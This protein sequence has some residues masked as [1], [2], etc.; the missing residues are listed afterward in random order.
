MALASLAL[1]RG[2]TAPVTAEVRSIDG[3]D[4]DRQVV[5][6]EV[7]GE[8][9]SGFRGVPLSLDDV[10]RWSRPPPTPPASEGMPL[11][12]VMASTGADIVEGIAALDGWGRLA[13]ALVD[14]SGIVPTIVVVDGPAVSGP[15]LLLGVADLVVMTEASYAFV[16][17]PVMVEEFTGVAGHHRRARRRGRPG[18]PHRRAEPRR[19][20]PRG[21]ARAPSS[22]L[23]DYL[24]VER[25]R[26]AA[27]AGRPTTRSTGRAP[28][29]AS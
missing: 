10:G 29:P 5:W 18:P 13:K 12:V 4:G 22:D 17:G 28:R 27:R 24:P 20:R 7:G 11:V 21:G 9:A 23:L 15:A 2:T 16:N 1:R 8:T 14:C 26:R 6:V 3:V 25:R 19:R